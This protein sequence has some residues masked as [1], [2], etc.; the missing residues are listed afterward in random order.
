M[1]KYNPVDMNKILKIKSTCKLFRTSAVYNFRI[2]LKK[3]KQKWSLNFSED[4]STDV[5]MN[6]IPCD[7]D[8]TTQPSSQ[9]EVKIWKIA[10]SS[11]QVICFIFVS[12]IK[13]EK[14]LSVSD[15]HKS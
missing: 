7:S 13:R 14:K 4:N 8:Q 12:T 6:H 5:L 11:Q 2:Q 10:I 9:K 15:A 1:Q 3:H